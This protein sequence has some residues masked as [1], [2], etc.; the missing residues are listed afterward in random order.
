MGMVIN[1][2]NVLLKFLNE[3]SYTSIMSKYFNEFVIFTLSASFLSIV[4]S[5][6][7]HETPIPL[8]FTEQLNKNELSSKKKTK[9][10]TKGSIVSL[11]VGLCE[12]VCVHIGVFLVPWCRLPFLDMQV[13]VTEKN[14]SRHSYFLCCLYYSSSQNACTGKLAL[15]STPC[16][17]NMTC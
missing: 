9:M 14:C 10:S 15:W 16:S 2:Q 12:D 17:P 4:N 8:N 13:L 5:S 7:Q 11:S 1:D 3:N 6:A